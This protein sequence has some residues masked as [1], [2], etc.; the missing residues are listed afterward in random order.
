MADE[1]RRG[2]KQATFAALPDKVAS[3]GEI[4][5][6]DEEGS[7]ETA[8]RRDVYSIHGEAVSSVWIEAHANARH[9]SSGR[10]CPSAGRATRHAP[11]ASPA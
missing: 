3:N 4:T 10:R 6:L 5:K 7:A 1:R 8:M 9:V 11:P 2:S